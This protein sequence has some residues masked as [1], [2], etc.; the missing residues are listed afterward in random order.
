M[1]KEER[2]YWAGILD[3]EGSILLTR[4]NPNKL[5]SPVISVTSTD[6]ELLEWL[7]EKLGGT[8]STK[9]K[10]KDHWSQAYDW[11]I[12]YSSAMK[13]LEYAY[14]YLQIKR[15][16]EKAKLLLN[17]YYLCTPKNGKYSEEMA[18]AK[19]QLILDFKNL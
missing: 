9:K 8:I 11:K 12:T 3:G 16:K 13:A 7:K 15:K 5:P 18:K 2:S 1:T 6:R 10:Y 14:P 4:M 17:R 19:Q